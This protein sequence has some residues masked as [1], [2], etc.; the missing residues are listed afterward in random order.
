MKKTLGK[1]LPVILIRNKMKN[2]LKNE[3]FFQ[4]LSKQ[5]AS[6]LLDSFTVIN[7]DKGRTVIDTYKKQKTTL[8][9][10]I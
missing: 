8:M 9:Y 10:I 3:S 6:K 1:S 2:I 5:Y 7:V 4:K